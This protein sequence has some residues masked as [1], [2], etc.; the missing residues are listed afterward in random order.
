MRA[1]KPHEIATGLK[2]CTPH[3]AGR[4]LGELRD[5][6]VEAIANGV[7]ESSPAAHVKPPRVVGLRKRL[8]LET[9]QSM[10]TLAK[11]GPQRWVPAMLLLAMA[12]GQRRADLAKMRFDDVVDG[13]LRIEQQKKARKL[14]GARVA[15]PLTLRLT[16]TDMTLGDVIEHCKTT[17]AP[18]ETLLRKA[19]GG[20]IEMSSLSA[21]FREHIVAVCGPEAYKQYEW[22]SLHEVRS[23]S[24]RTYIAEGMAASTVQ[25][26]LGHKHAEM[27][28]L[29]LNDRGLTDGD[30]K[31]VEPAQQ[32]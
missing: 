27:T 28:A 9:W 23:L 3:K 7:A 1:I 31:V 30:W 20:P 15:I 17:G 22:P 14:V 12:T 6:Y 2:L 26:L 4:I 18:G 11:A 29:Y 10:L 21:R 19:G 13:C 32:Q 16:A 25:T 8:T 5:V 24:A